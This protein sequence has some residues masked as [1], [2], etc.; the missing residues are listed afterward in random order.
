MGKALG[1]LIKNREGHRMLSRSLMGYRKAVVLVAIFFLLCL[2]WG[3]KFLFFLILFAA[4]CTCAWYLFKL[5]PYWRSSYFLQTHK[6]YFQM[7]FDTGN[8][9]EYLTYV[10]LKG[11]EKNGAKYIFNSYIPKEDGKTTEIDLIMIYR[12]GIY[13]FESKNYSGWIFGN[14]KQKTWT[15][16]LPNGRSSR[17]EHFLNP[18]MQNKLHIANLKRLLDE[19]YPIHSIVVFSNRCT[20]K[21]IE[22]TSNDV[23]VDYRDRILSI[24]NEIDNNNSTVMEEGDIERVY[25]ILYPY[26]Q[27]PDTVKAQHIQDIEDNIN[28]QKTES[29]QLE[30]QKAPD[31]CPRCGGKLVL[32]TAK[33]GTNAG[34][35]FYGCSNYPKCRYIQNG[36]DA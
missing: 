3:F 11:Y 21:D 27:A 29:E 13:V 16:T 33:K 25:S 9:G 26:T 8:Y 30:G 20:L 35:Q 5:K 17:K 36:I 1:V 28:M 18:I 2:S 19:Q 15:Q 22:V 12:S 32:R 4:L 34:Q 6:T 23:V 7:R 10:E 31:V 14:E 24:V